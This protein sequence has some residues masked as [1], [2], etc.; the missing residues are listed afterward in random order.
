MGGDREVEKKAKMGAQL[1]TIASRIPL[2]AVNHK[3]QHLVD[4]I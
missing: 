3:F 2:G 4:P 1:K